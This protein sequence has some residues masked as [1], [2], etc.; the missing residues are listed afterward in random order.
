[1]VHEAHT[2]CSCAGSSGSED[3][4]QSLETRRMPSGD[5]VLGV[6]FLTQTM[7]GLLG[8]FSLLYHY[9]FL[10]FTGVRLRSKDLILKHMIVANSLS[11]LCKGI[12]QTMESFGWNRY[13]SDI[14]CKLLFYLHRVG[15]GVTLGTNCL[16]SV[17]QAV[18][19]SSRNSRWAELK[20]KAVNYI[21]PSLFLCWIL[22][23]LVNVIYLMFVSSNWS[24]K[25]ITNQKHFG[26]CS[27]IR[28]DKT[29]D[30]LYAALLSIP[31][32][33]CFGLLLWASGSMVFIL[34]RHKQRVQYIH[35]TNVF[36]RSS[37][38][39]R[40]TQSILVLVST[41]V[42]F[43]S[44]SSIFQICIG[45]FDNPKWLLVNISAL[46]NGCFPTACPFVLRNRDSSI[47]RLCFAPMWITK[48]P[49]HMIN[50]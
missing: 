15:R 1:M 26:Y 4:F 13:P 7:V 16:L 12:P 42:S 18:T 43:Y 31:D 19:I 50:K 48:S 38:E 9:L 10:Y 45:I 25:N 22:H 47:S 6:I 34:Y 30:S 36:P 49:K 3:K 14:G 11:L 21:I 41:F 24:K 8:N 35:R 39:S 27:T 46:I 2:S 20:V 17:F 5:V 44:L 23:L 40:A 32:V 29:R 28:H 33:F 37:P